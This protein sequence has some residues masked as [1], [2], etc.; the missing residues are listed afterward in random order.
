MLIEYR[1]EVRGGAVTI[2]HHIELGDT[3]SVTAQQPDAGVKS[4]TTPGKVS[5]IDVPQSFGVQETAS[6]ATKSG[7]GGH[8]STSTG[9]SGPAS[10]LVIVLGPVVVLPSGGPGSGGGGHD[11]TGTGG[12]GQKSTA[13]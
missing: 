2:S 12:G 7:G 5:V 13:N 11:P 8:D 1:I 3:A 9:G 4:Q 10:G 6:T